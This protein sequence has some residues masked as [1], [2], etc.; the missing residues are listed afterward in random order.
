MAEKQARAA[1]IRRL[2][3]KI[4]EDHARVS[5][6]L[7]ALAS[8]KGIELA[9]GRPR[10]PKLSESDFDREYLDLVQEDHRQDIAEF[11]KAVRELQDA[12]L[13]RFAEKTLPVLR[14]HLELVKK[15]RNKIKLTS[16]E[17]NVAR[18]ATSNSD[19]ET[20][21]NETNKER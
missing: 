2:G 15:A 11:E 4:A 20:S 9:L 19:A 6:E 12:D 21:R 18:P 14:R 5:R 1:E 7:A 3:A 8:E 16:R 10:L 17:V 13:K